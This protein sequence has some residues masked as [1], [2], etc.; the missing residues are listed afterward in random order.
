MNVRFREN[1]WIGEKSLVECYP[2]LFK[3]SSHKEKSI[4]EFVENSQ[5]P[6][7]DALN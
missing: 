5:D 6:S 2:L 7:G 4:S 1:W 3:L